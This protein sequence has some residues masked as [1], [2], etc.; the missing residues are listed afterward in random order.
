MEL[1]GRILNI[2]TDDKKIA[3]AISMSMIKEDTD[4]QL[5][6]AY[7]LG[8][9]D[10]R[11]EAAHKAMIGVRAINTLKGLVDH[12]KRLR[13]ISVDQTVKESRLEP[14]ENILHEEDQESALN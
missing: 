12:I 6:M 13:K 4:E 7:K 2:Q 10:A 8:H 14:A 3:T 1:D 9:R 5:R 11:H